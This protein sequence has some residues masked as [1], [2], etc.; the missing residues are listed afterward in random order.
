VSC[1]DELGHGRGQ[2]AGNIHVENREIEIGGL[3]QRER[4]FEPCC[5]SRNVVT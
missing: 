5:L 1:R 2:L 3:R 4:L